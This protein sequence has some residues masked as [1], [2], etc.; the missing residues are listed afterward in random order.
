MDFKILRSIE[1]QTDGKKIPVHFE[2]LRVSKENNALTTYG[3]MLVNEQL[4]MN[5]EYEIS[6]TRCN[7]DSSGCI[8]FHKVSFPKICEKVEAKTSVAYEIARGIF[9]RP[10]C[11]ISAGTYEIKNN[12]TFLLNQFILLPVDG[13]L[14]QTKH[15]FYEKKNLKRVRLLAC[16]EFELIAKRVRVQVS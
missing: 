9:P 4:P 15:I 1:C 5:L 8:F 10:H 6:I 2:E 7:L 3:R 16:I 12:S 13:F 14:W 11:P